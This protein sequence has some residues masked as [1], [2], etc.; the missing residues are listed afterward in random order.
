MGVLHLQ[1]LIK[2]SKP[3]QGRKISWILP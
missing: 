2:R 3:H 1:G